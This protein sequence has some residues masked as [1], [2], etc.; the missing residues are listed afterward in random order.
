MLLSS[1]RLYRLSATLPFIR[2]EIV[3][4]LASKQQ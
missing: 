2:S 4:G 3:D 1:L